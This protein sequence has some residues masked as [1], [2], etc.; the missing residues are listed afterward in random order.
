[1]RP[2]LA[3]AADGQAPATGGKDGLV[4]VWTPERR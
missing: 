1:L 4:K 3:F 2:P